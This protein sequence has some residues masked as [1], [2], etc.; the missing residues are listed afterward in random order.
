[1]IVTIEG[2]SAAGKTTWCRLHCPKGFVEGAQENISAPDL[3]SDP[4]EVAQFWVNFNIGRWHA[5]LGIES[6]RGIAVCDGDPFGLCFSW[7]VWKAG[8]IPGRLF[9]IEQPLYRRAIEERRLG[10]ADA[11]IWFDAPLEELRQ[12]AKSDTTRRRKRHEL[13]LRMI[14]RMKTWADARQQA[15]PGTVRVRPDDFRA[16]DLENIAALARRYDPA[17]VDE[18]IKALDAGDSFSKTAGAN[19]I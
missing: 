4:E 16:E 2:P 18:M 14:P 10:F 7:A 13:Y 17:I 1:M 3:Y 6:E 12:R 11:V 19:S 8:A 15:L 5:A 9:E